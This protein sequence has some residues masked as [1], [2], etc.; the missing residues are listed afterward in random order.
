MLVCMKSADDRL[1][2]QEWKGENVSYLMGDH[3]DGA[4]GCST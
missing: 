2:L 1:R 3:A 4:R